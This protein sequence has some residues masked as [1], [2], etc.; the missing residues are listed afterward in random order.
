M[1]HRELEL[2]CMDKEDR[3]A[4]K[5]RRV[6]IAANAIDKL[7]TLGR[8]PNRSTTTALEASR[9]VEAVT[10]RPRRGRDLADY[11]QAFLDGDLDRG[12]IAP[13]RAPAP[14]KPLDLGCTL[15]GLQRNFARAEQVQPRLYTPNGYGNYSRS[16][17]GS[18]GKQ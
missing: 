16:W 4:Y 15:P 7:W 18:E 13:S 3:E 12:Q 6:A 11:L 14:F 1:A 17:G 10:G 8:R 2:N 9:M 5:A